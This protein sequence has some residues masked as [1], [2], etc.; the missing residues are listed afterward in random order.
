MQAS[1]S[2]SSVTTAEG[3]HSSSWQLYV[4]LALRF[5]HLRRTI[6]TAESHSHVLLQAFLQLPPDENLLPSL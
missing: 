5:Y 4:A 3:V 6:S 2:R 1:S